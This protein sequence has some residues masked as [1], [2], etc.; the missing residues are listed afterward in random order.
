[1]DE[2]SRYSPTVLV[3]QGICHHRGHKGI[4]WAFS[5]QG[6]ALSTTSCPVKDGVCSVVC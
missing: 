6:F 3:Q 4:T 2:R 5:E 1:M